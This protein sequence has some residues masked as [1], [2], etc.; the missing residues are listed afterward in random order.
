MEDVAG[1]AETKIRYIREGK[2]ECLKLSG[3]YKL[4]I[5]GDV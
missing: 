1:N 2:K 5:D 4:R 3:F